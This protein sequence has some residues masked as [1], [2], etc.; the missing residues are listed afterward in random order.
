MHD[1]LNGVSR[2]ARCTSAWTKAT[3]MAVLCISLAC[4]SALADLRPESWLVAEQARTN[5]TAAPA[6]QANVV[7]GNR[8]SASPQPSRFPI[9]TSQPSGGRENPQSSPHRG[10]HRRLWPFQTPETPADNLRNRDLRPESRHAISPGV[11]APGAG[12]DRL[13]QPTPVPAFSRL[14]PQ[15]RVEPAPQLQPSIQFQPSTQPQPAPRSQP[16]YLSPSMPEPH[17]ASQDRASQQG[18]PGTPSHTWHQSSASFPANPI[19]TELPRRDLRR[20]LTDDTEQPE[21]TLLFEADDRSP[22]SIWTSLALW[23]TPDGGDEPGSNA[24]GTARDLES[25]DSIGEEP[26]QDNSLQFLRNNTVLLEPGQLQVDYGL[27]YTMVEN[28]FPVAVTD[29]G[30]VVTGAV[31]GRVRPRTLTVPFQARYGLNELAQLFIDVPVG[32]NGAELSFSGFDEFSNT[33]GVGDIRMGTSILLRKGCCED[34]ADLVGTFAMTFPTGNGA[35][36]TLGLSPDAQLGEGFFAMSLNLLW[37]K[38]IDPLVFFY[39]G[40]YR[41]RFDESFQGNQV[42]PGEQFNYQFGVGFAVNERVTLSTAYLGAYITE[43][44]VNGDRIEGSILEPSRLRFSATISKLSRFHHW[45][46]ETCLQ[47]ILEPF[48]EIGM[49]NDAASTRFGIVWTL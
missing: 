15:P 39:G 7:P 1:N 24:D 27:I 5:E 44:Q 10:L 28:E 22:E 8:R 18:Y 35:F 40:G 20:L 9:V 37:I 23:Q 30:G 33:V 29:G 16:L 48:V 25:A 41:H 13:Q 43:N 34:E 21:P 45:R 42:D 46:G 49:T 3:L 14:Q 19:P 31:R 32:W 4:D 12:L 11:P 6:A 17:L 2:Q 26:P 38:T 47:T 36:P